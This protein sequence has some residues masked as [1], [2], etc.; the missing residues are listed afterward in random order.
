MANLHLVNILENHG[1]S[2][3]HD[4]VA[5]QTKPKDLG[6]CRKPD[7]LEHT[8]L[9]GQHPQHPQHQL[10][11]MNAAS[12]TNNL[13]MTE[14]NHDH[15]GSQGGKQRRQGGKIRRQASMSSLNK[16]NKK[17]IIFKIEINTCNISYCNIS[18]CQCNMF[19]DSSSRTQASE[20]EIKHRLQVED[21]GRCKEQ[22]SSMNSIKSQKHNIPP[23]VESTTF[24]FM[25]KA[26]YSTSRGN[27]TSTSCGHNLFYP[28]RVGRNFCFNT[29]N[30]KNNIYQINNIYPKT[31]QLKKNQT[32][33][34]N[35]L[36][37]IQT[38]V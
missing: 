25:W 6:Q 29:K 13:D 15:E 20:N 31:Q 21:K 26:F 17:K 27:Q 36:Y 32:E 8:G 30:Y 12:I 37:Q 19:I 10:G 5:I 3:E 33:A 1:G 18:Y 35:K 28:P 23:C 11:L 24:H 22:T 34:L 38:N 7:Q 2:G 4:Y 14:A 9:L 16:E